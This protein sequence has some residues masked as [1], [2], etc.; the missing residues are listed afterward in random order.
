MFSRRLLESQN[1]YSFVSLV[2]SCFAVEAWHD[3]SA[4]VVKTYYSPTYRLKDGASGAARFSGG[5]VMQQPVA[6]PNQI[7]VL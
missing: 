4:L 3:F 7:V 2:R 5:S 6:A 1:G